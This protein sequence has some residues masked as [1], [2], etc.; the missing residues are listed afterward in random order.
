M[1][2]HCTLMVIF[3]LFKSRYFSTKVIFH[4]MAKCKG[5]DTNQLLQLIVKWQ[6]FILL[7]KLGK[8]YKRNLKKLSYENLNKC[9]H[10]LSLD[11]TN[12]SSPPHGT[13]DEDEDVHT[14]F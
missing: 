11:T 5:T 6:A 9:R 13:C 8:K 2:V 7:T 4:F 12:L 3:F 10:T 14:Y 1:N